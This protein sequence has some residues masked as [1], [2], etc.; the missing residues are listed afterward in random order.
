MN[1]QGAYVYRNHRLM[2]WGEWFRLIPK[3]EATKYARVQINFDKKIDDLWAIDIKNLKLHHHLQ[4][5]KGLNR[6]SAEYRKLVLDCHLEELI[7]L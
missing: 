4:F 5:W 2:V 3:S 6:L 1:N 7:K